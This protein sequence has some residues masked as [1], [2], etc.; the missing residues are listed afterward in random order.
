MESI[1]ESKGKV[2]V[3][4]GDGSK[5]WLLDLTP[6]G[7]IYTNNELDAKVFSKK[8]LEGLNGTYS[9]IIK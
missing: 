8:E 1:M 9:F 2:L 7:P 4:H 6:S 5:S 3:K